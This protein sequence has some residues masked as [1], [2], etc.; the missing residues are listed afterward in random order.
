MNTYLQV[1][2]LLYSDK[3]TTRGVC[4]RFCSKSGYIIYTCMRYENTQKETSHYPLLLLAI[5]KLMGSATSPFGDFH[6][7]YKSTLYQTFNKIGDKHLL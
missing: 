1:Y 2:W 3:E 7:L 4:R 6:I 5:A